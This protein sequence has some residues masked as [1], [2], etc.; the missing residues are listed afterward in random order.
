MRLG[1]LTALVGV[2]CAGH[3]GEPPCG[4]VGAPSVGAGPA[5]GGNVLV[6]LLDDVGA[7]VLSAYGATGLVAPTPVIEC[8]CDRG[9]R[10]TRA[11]AAPLCS[12]G[13]AALA[14]GRLADR[15]GMGDNVGRQGALPSTESTIGDAARAAGMAT[16]WVGKWHLSGWDAPDGIDAPLRS[17][18]DRF[19]GTLANLDV[20]AVQGDRV[21]DYR[22]Y[23]WIRDGEVRWRTTYATTLTVD[24][25][26]D[27]VRDE[28]RDEPGIPWLLVV[29]THAVHEPLDAPPARLARGPFDATP[30][31]PFRAVL[32]AVD[33]ELG[34]LLHGLGPDVL[35]DTT[36]VLTSDNGTSEEG[37]P[38]D[39]DDRVKATL[40]EG[41][42]HVPLVVTG[43][44]VAHPGVSSALVSLVDLL[45]TVVDIA[46][47][48]LPAGL[49]GVSLVPWLDDPE[50]PGPAYVHAAWDAARDVDG[51]DRA[52]RGE[53][54]K[55]IQPATG[56]AS[57]FDLVADPEER[58][59]LVSA[60]PLADDA[61]E[62]LADLAPRVDAEADRGLVE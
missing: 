43:P 51:F 37:T 59:D 14:T 17:G 53:R 38:A 39:R 2:A 25:A 40:F 20:A 45:P 62:A 47:G 10:F 49:D 29:A 8:L 19:S 42:L 18:F 36:V 26:L 48:E 6:V 28:A 12:P 16:G 15:N 57:L 22:G 41:G 55:L 24:E 4:A 1:S 7:D 46:G 61:A 27:F 56:P 54:F 31:A 33:T 58:T 23:W 13:R 50:A 30:E 32:E 44:V 60:G 3:R 35:A 11:W 52:V 5:G 21:G 34:R 9:V